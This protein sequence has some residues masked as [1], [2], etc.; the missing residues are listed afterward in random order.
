MSSTVVS[1]KRVE[2][3]RPPTDIELC[4]LPSTALRSAGAFGHFSSEPPLLQ[5][6]TAILRA[7]QLLGLYPLPLVGVQPFNRVLSFNKAFLLV[8]LSLIF[9]LLNLSVL[10]INVYITVQLT[11]FYGWLYPMTLSSVVTGLKPLINFVNF[12][13]FWISA[14]RHRRF[15]RDLM[16]IDNHLIELYD[17]TPNMRAIGQR[18]FCFIILSAL[19]PMSLRAI[20]YIWMSEQ[21]GESLLNDLSLVLVPLLSIWNMIP[22]AYFWVINVMLRSYFRALHQALRKDVHLREKSLRFYFNQF[23]KLS[24][25]TTKMTLLFTPFLAFTIFWTVLTL[26]LSINFLTQTGKFLPMEL[27]RAMKESQGN[28]IIV[29][30]NLG[31]C[32]MQ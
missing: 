18:F 20:E 21:P 4:T 11:S 9:F 12:L 7:V 2:R 5:R 15:L 28:S 1:G 3:N 31:Y 29:Y 23:R 13:I 25:M 19:I 16:I 17:S 24:Q 8:L 26:C 10:S 30:F 27:E 22:L 14:M 32:V 6:M